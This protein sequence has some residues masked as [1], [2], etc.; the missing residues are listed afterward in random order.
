MNNNSKTD[1]D[2][3]WKDAIANY[4]KEFMQFFFPD[5]YA[6][7]EFGKGFVF[8]DKEFQKIVKESADKK[9]YVDKLVQ[10]YLK[11]GEEKWILIHIEV[12]GSFEKDFA[13]RLYVYNYRIY[14]RYKKKVIT[15][16]I[17]TDENKNYRPDTFEIN[18]WGFVNIF[19]FPVIKLLDYKD[20]I[21]IERAKNQFEIITFAHLKNLE[22]KKDN[23]N[24][25]VLEDN[26]SKTSL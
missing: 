10:V 23:E 2:G 18:M 4:F 5:I 3:G 9:R 20:K 25:A 12:H 16:A 11:S 26:I 19:Q 13:E 24:K 17:L 1:Y 14:D 22:L 15:L 7:I 21:D 6:D 8:L